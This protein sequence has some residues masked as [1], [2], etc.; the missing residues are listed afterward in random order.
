MPIITMNF[1]ENSYCGR[2]IE[3]KLNKFTFVEKDWI[4]YK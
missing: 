2:G 3:K 4:N 1:G